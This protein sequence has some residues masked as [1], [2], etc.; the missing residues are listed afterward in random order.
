MN[1]SFALILFSKNCCY[2]RKYKGK[3]VIF[4]FLF[5]ISEVAFECN[6]MSQCIY[7]TVTNSTCTVLQQRNVHCHYSNIQDKNL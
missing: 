4:I 3:F 5:E 7:L 6:E 2:K 1:L